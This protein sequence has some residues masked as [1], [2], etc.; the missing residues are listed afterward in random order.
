MYTLHNVITI[1][2][3]FA[4]AHKQINSFLFQVL[5]DDQPDVAVRYPLLMCEIENSEIGEQQDLYRLSFVICDIPNQDDNKRDVRTI[6]SD[7]KLIANDLVAYLRYT[8]FGEFMRVDA[9][10]TL[11]PVYDAGEDGFSGWQFALNFRL[12]QGLNSCNIPM[13]GVS[14]PNTNVVIIYDQDGNELER[15]SAPGVY[16]VTVFDAIQDTIDN[17]TTTITPL[18]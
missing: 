2:E 14:H 8:R 18:I 4:N 10:A 3:Q 6:L 7:T 12:N 5:P 11:S 15:I 17:N 13:T 9:P 1:L 16:F